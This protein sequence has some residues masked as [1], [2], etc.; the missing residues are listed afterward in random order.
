VHDR[1]ALLVLQ[2]KEVGVDRLLDARV[3]GG[4]RLEPVVFLEFAGWLAFHTY[5]QA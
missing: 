3:D 4:D 5:G 2:L 1:V